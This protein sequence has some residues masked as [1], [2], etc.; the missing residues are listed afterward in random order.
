M[1]KVSTPEPE[2][3]A[4]NEWLVEAAEA[5]AALCRA[6]PDVTPQI[7]KELYKKQKAAI[8]GRFWGKCAYCEVLLTG[9]HPGDVEHYRPKSEVT[10]DD[11]KPIVNPRTGLSHPGY[12]WVAYDPT[13]LLPACADCNRPSKGAR[14]QKLG[15]RTQFPIQGKRAFGPDDPLKL[16]EP[17][18]INP[19]LDD[20]E[21][22]L[23]FDEM[24]IAAGRTAKGER[25]VAVLGLNR[26]GLIDERRRACSDAKGLLVRL[27][28]AVVDGPPER[29][30]EIAKEIS[31]YKE[32]AKP[33]SAAV[34]KLLE[35]VASDYAASL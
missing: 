19:L 11:S 1:I 8:L 20:P 30:A 14:K 33:Y 25:T 15:K 4:W 24:C 16:E 13:N 18:L 32:G 6:K 35:R 22:D 23:L 9:N 7:D 10:G 5:C 28:A 34:R 31:L 27:G 2:D 17:L 26:D 21:E 12:Y 29:R 3:A